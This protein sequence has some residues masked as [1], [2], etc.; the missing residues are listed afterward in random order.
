MKKIISIIFA[1]ILTISLIS[2]FSFAQISR[3]KVQFE[4]TE[5]HK[6]IVYPPLEFWGS[7][8]GNLFSLYKTT[9]ARGTWK[10]ICTEFCQ[11]EEG[12]ALLQGCTC[13][14]GVNVNQLESEIDI[15]DARMII[16][17]EYIAD[18]RAL[19]WLRLN[20]DLNQAPLGLLPFFREFY[21][22][23]VE[24]DAL[25]SLS[26]EDLIE[27]EKDG[28]LEKGILKISNSKV[29]IKR[30]IYPNDR[31]NRNIFL[32]NATI[33]FNNKRINLDVNG[34]Y[35]YGI[36]KS[37]CGSK[38]VAIDS[39]TIKKV[40]EGN[41]EIPYSPGALNSCSSFVMSLNEYRNYENN[42]FKNFARASVVYFT[43]LFSGTSKVCVIS[44]TR[45][46]EYYSVCNNDYTPITIIPT[47]RSSFVLHF[48]EGE[49]AQSLANVFCGSKT[50]SAY[51]NYGD[52]TSSIAKPNIRLNN[53]KCFKLALPDY[54]GTYGSVVDLVVT[55]EGEAEFQEKV[56]VSNEG[57]LMF[58]PNPTLDWGSDNRIA[59]GE[60]EMSSENGITT[61]GKFS[62]IDPLNNNLIDF[63]RSV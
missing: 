45:F 63:I 51:A 28:H 30:I 41:L 26:S 56:Y 61:L 17:G 4:I 55:S 42:I 19:E 40:G 59:Y 25:N 33:D 43:Q 32:Q 16:T 18:N 62:M 8:Y 37:P 57:D 13:Y 7:E 29:N 3:E 1:I 5:D 27:V 53:I 35:D 11:V 54:S 34:E 60:K 44:D 14:P 24:Q 22:P 12:S 52:P 49:T 46:Q 50:Y 36:T 20:T 6:L 31:T 2:D 9:S 47:D 10:K 48:N 23:I 21:N 39:I 38:L 15:T 58:N